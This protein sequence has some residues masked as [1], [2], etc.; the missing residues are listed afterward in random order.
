MGSA[1]VAGQLGMVQVMLVALA[2]KIVQF[3][4]PQTL[5]DGVAL[6]RSKLVPVNVSVAPGANAAVERA[7]KVGVL[8]PSS[9]RL[10][11]ESVEG[12]RY[13]EEIAEDD[14]PPHRY[15]SSSPDFIESTELISNNE[16]ASCLVEVRTG[17]FVIRN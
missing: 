14:G 15:P 13:T 5:T 17:S 1:D 4:P 7:P 2:V 11:G 10:Q 8:E 3:R 9:V 6:V 12:V 16:T